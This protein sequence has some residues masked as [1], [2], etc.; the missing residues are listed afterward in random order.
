[1]ATKKNFTSI[2]PATSFISAVQ[3]DEKETVNEQPTAKAPRTRKPKAPQ[4]PITLPT[5]EIKL[6]TLN[7]VSSILKVTV[8]TIYR[9]IDAGEL[10]ASKIGKSWRVSSEDL[11]SFIGG[12][13]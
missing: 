9:Y 10:K 7:E 8:R 12:H 11:K 6:Y 3:N 5:D 1:M 2:N 4:Q 13:N